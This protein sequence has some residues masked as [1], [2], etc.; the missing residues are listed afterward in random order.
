M[1][2]NQAGQESLKQGVPCCNEMI[3]RPCKG[4]SLLSEELGNTAPQSVEALAR[5]GAR[6]RV[7]GHMQRDVTRLATDGDGE[8]CQQ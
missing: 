5:C 7:A 3:N 2:G 6:G 8:A 4:E 1:C